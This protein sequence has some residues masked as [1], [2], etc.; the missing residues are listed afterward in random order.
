MVIVLALILLG[1]AYLWLTK[2]RLDRELERDLEAEPR[3]ADGHPRAA[4]PRARDPEET[5][6]RPTV[7]RSGRV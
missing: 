3:V 7:I 4:E 6:A 2:R 1:V 5:Y